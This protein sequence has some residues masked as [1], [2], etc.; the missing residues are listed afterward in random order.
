[1]NT[2]AYTISGNK[3]ITEPQVAKSGF[4]MAPGRKTEYTF[5]V[6]GNTL[7]LAQQDGPTVKFTRAE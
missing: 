2:G 3:L 7:T 5:T 4:A 1:M 6:S